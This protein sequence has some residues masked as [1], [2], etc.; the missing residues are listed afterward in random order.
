LEKQKKGGEKLSCQISLSFLF[1]KKEKKQKKGGKA[2]QKRKSKKSST[3]KVFA[4]ANKAR[5][6]L[7]NSFTLLPA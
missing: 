7:K 4:A 3:Q 5:A 1:L 6:Q 2:K